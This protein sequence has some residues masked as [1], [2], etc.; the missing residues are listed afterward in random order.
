MMAAENHDA[1]EAERAASKTPEYFAAIYEEGPDPWGFESS[2]YEREKYTATLAA[3]TRPRYSSAFEI[4][5]SVGVLTELLAARCRRLLA[6][7]IVDTPL[8]LA[9]ERC[10]ELGSV[11]F[12]RMQ[13]P[14]EFPDEI[15]DL[16][17]LSEVGYYWSREDL[18][19]A[20]D[21]IVEHLNPRGQLLL[22]HWRPE[23]AG[24]PLTGDEVHALVAARSAGS[25]QHRFGESQPSYRLDLWERAGH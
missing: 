16:I 17:V 18:E 19:R 20:T 14:D 3:L 8:A 9:R 25:L 4:G 23:I 13:V 11:C 6:V 7:D 24:C 15:F 1:R 2:S 10:R 5:C 21:L 12:A 22:A